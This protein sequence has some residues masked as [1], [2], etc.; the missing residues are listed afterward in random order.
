[1]HGGFILYIGWRTRF[2]EPVRYTAKQ[3]MA[4][5]QTKRFELSIS[6]S[7]TT[8][9]VGNLAGSAFIENQGRRV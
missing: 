7:P 9:P 1:M 8:V 5:V 3:I 2:P 6:S 4:S